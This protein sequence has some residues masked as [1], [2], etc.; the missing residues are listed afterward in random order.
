MLLTVDVD[1]ITHWPGG[2]FTCEQTCYNSYNRVICLNR[3]YTA[4]DRSQK[5]DYKYT[6]LRTITAGFQTPDCIGEIAND[7]LQRTHC[8]G[9]RSFQIYFKSVTWL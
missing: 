8:K 4:K 2:F 1:S 6:R 5:A 7:R 9:R 3:K